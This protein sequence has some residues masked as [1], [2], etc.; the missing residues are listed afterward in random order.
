[1]MRAGIDRRLIASLSV[2]KRLFD[3]LVDE[4]ASSPATATPT[5][6]C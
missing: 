2:S 5:S 4:G 6:F 1:M 3:T